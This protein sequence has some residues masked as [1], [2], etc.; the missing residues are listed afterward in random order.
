MSIGVANI[1]ISNMVYLDSLHDGLGREDVQSTLFCMPA[2]RGS[3]VNGEELSTLLL[4][5]VI[6]KEKGI[7]HRVGC[8]CGDMSTEEWNTILAF[9]EGEENFPCEDFQDGYHYIRII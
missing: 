1:T 3:T 6:D 2:S 5:Q 7:F 4:L 8:F 9:N